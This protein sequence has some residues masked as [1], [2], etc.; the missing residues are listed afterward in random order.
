M[1]NIL[2]VDDRSDIRLSLAL[3]LEDNG[4]TIFE[5]DNPQMAQVVIKQ[6]AIDVIV[7]DMNFTLDTTSGEEGLGFLRWLKESEIAIPVVAMT[8]WTNT[9][10]VVQAMKAGA[11]D[12]IEKP[13]RNKQMLH[14]IEQQLSIQSLQQE[15]AK[16]KQLFNDSGDEH[17]VWQ[18]TAMT[19][20]FKKIE[21]VADTD[22]SV[23]FTGENGTGKSECAHYL[24]RLSGRNDGTFV[25]VNMGAITETLFESEMFGHKKG[26][27]T[28]AKADRI[29]R[30]ELA[31]GG[32]LFLDEISNIPVSQ[33]NKL[34]RVLESGEY[35]A[36]GSN[37]TMKADVRIVSATNADLASLISQGDFRQDLYFRLNTIELDIPP[38]RARKSDLLPLADYLIQGFARR[39][40]RNVNGL[41]TSAQSAIKSYAWP[42]NV[43]EMRHLIERAVLLASSDTI[44]AEDLHISSVANASTLENT[45]PMMTLAEAE[46]NLLKQAL[47]QTD[48]HVANAAKLVGLTKSSM[49]RRL[50]KYG[51]S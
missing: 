29:G 19:G 1:A 22:V 46:V 24:H 32:T 50:E 47:I 36:V 14:A 45:L 2:V 39:Y 44:E 21:A 12:F 16:Y 8:A 5:A 4:Y 15:N 48:N 9:E 30:F 38:L 49:Y 3:L 42:G 33:Q 34:L 51:L 25:S 6:E 7:L 27:F 18:S 23:L 20:L 28:D 37:K 40:Q 13:W 26:A 31:K 35:E 17:Y 11:S 43:R 10:L 41:S